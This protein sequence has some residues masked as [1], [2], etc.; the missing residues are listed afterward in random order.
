MK[1]INRLFRKYFKKENLSDLRFLSKGEKTLLKNFSIEVRGQDK[2]RQYLFIGDES[3]ISGNYIFETSS[4]TITIGNGT[5]IGG[6]I[7]ICIDNII[8]GNNVMFSWGCTVVDNDAHSLLSK[9]RISDIKDWKCGLEDGEIGTYKIGRA[10]C[11][12]R[13]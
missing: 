4:G 6:G 1:Y 2:S 7:F 13:V 10:S 5:F 8:I 9:E 11:R 12:E 3:I